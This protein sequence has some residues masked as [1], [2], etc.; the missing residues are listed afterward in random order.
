MRILVLSKRRYTGK[1]LLDDRYGRLYEIPAG[2]VARG[3]AVVGNNRGQTTIS[4]ITE[5]L[6][7]LQSWILE[8]KESADAGSRE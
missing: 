1:D 5:Q 7:A 6:N 2:L 3:H 8:M 4:T